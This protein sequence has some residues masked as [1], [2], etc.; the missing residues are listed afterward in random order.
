MVVLSISKLHVG[1][2]LPDFTYETPY[3]QGLS[4]AGTARQVKGKTALYFL[5]YYGCTMCQ[6]D[7]H[8]LTEAADAIKAAG[9]QVLAVLQSDPQLLR[10]EL[11]EGYP[12]F[13]IICDPKETLYKRF[14]ILPAASK[15]EMRGEITMKKRPQALA[16]GYTHGKYEG[17]ELQLPATFVVTPELEITYAYYGKAVGDSP[18]AETLLELLK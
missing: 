13:R 12:P 5:R 7:L 18:D 14:E 4:I 11:P 6:Y 15:E 9:G 3:T 16:L 2:I 1:D 17:N 10:E 8:L